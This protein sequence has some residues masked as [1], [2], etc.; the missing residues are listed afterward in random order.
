[1]VIGAKAARE[2]PYLSFAGNRHRRF[3]YQ[4]LIAF[5]IVYVLLR[6]VVP[7]V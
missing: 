1:M 2:L 4:E 5:Q 7:A 3:G 6:R